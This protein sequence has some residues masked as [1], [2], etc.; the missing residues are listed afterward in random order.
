VTFQYT[1]SAEELGPHWLGFPVEVR[2]DSGS[3]IGG[4]LLSYDIGDAESTVLI[5]TCGKVAVTTKSTIIV[6]VHFP[7]Q[8]RQ[9]IARAQQPALDDASTVQWDPT[10]TVTDAKPRP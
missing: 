4:R 9:P 5:E 10:E 2:N 6:T 1:I 7:Y 3:R 8:L